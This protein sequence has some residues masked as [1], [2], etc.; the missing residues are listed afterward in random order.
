[1]Q[2]KMVQKRPFGDD[3]LY[4][5]SCKHPRQLECSNQL[6]PFLDIVSHQDA[7]LKPLISGESSMLKVTIWLHYSR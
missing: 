6:P 7:F 5:L 1:M 2:L 4:D 3:K